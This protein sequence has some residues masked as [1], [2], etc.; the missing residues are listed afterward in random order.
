MSRK[1][2][3]LPATGPQNVAKQPAARPAAPAP[4]SAPDVSV[5]TSGGVPWVGVGAFLLLVGVVGAL[6]LMRDEAAPPKSGPP[7]GPGKQVTTDPWKKALED[8]AARGNRRWEPEPWVPVGEADHLVD[9]FVALKQAD[10][11]ALMLGEPVFGVDWFAALKKAVD[12]AAEDVLGGRPLTE[13][14]VINEAELEARAT[15]TFLRQRFTLTAIYRG[16]PDG[17]GG[18]R[19]TANRYTLAGVGPVR[20]PII[21]IRWAHG[22][23]GPSSSFITKE[24]ELVVEVRG[25]KIHGVRSHPGR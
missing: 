12:A 2:K 16:E 17:Q 5:P 22:D 13:G 25:G 11:R 19:N 10:S 3:Y 15:D 6:L 21:R 23:E 20:S 7:V 9:W 24:L 8:L 4:A 18:Q 1:K 14:E